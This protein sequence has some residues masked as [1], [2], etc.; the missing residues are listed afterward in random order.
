MPAFARPNAAHCLAQVVAPD[1]RRLVTCKG[2]P[3][4]VRDLLQD[5]GA[6]QAVDRW[7]APEGLFLTLL[8]C[9]GQP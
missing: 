5:N 9:S 6:R 2:A 7:V 3:Q 4:I 8:L 1:G